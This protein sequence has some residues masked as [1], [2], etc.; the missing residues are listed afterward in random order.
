M[1]QPYETPQQSAQT[2]YP[3][4]PMAPVMTMGQWLVSMLLMVIPLVNIILLIVWAVS[5]VE[6]PN[7]RNW[8][9]AQLVMMVV[10][11]VLWFLLAGAI[12]GVLGSLT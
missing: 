8:A 5:S 3:Q 9:K 1:E 6:N 7:R 11:I 12:L 4:Q 2:Y 10:V